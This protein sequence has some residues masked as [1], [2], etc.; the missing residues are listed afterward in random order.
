ML[1]SPELSTSAH[2]VWLNTGM[3]FCASPTARKSAMAILSRWE[4]VIIPLKSGSWDASTNS[5][6]PATIASQN[7]FLISASIRR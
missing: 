2:K 5:P 1:K 4:L 6:P 3:S 7:S